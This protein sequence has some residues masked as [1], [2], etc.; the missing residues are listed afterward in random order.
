MNNP[1]IPAPKDDTSVSD[2]RTGLASS[3]SQTTL[4]VET[5]PPAPQKGKDQPALDDAWLRDFYKE[6]GR[7][8]TL[9][10]TTLNQMKN[11]AIVVQ[12]SIIAAV[13]AF[14]R[15]L[16]SSS[17]S[18]VGSQ[19]G[20]AVVVGAVLAHLFTLRFFVRA[21]LC[22]INLLRWNKLQSA[23]VECKLVRREVLRGQPNPQAEPES[24][25]RKA[26]QDYYFR[27]LSP[28][29][30]PAQIA[31]NLKLGFGLLLVLPAV[32]I[33]WGTAVHWDMLVVRGLVTFAIIGTLIEVEDY[34]LAGFFDT[35]DR[36]AERKEDKM[37][38]P[39]PSGSIS[40][41]SMWDINSLVSTGVA[42]GPQLVNFC[43]PL[44][45]PGEL[46]WAVTYALAAYL[47][48]YIAYNGF[49]AWHRRLTQWRG[50]VLMS[51]LALVALTVLVVPSWIAV[52]AAASTAAIAGAGALL[53]P[54][55]QR[56]Q[57][58]A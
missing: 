46:P 16:L 28:V 17:G 22:Y 20:I 52:I 15:S 58:D 44:L 12:A 45:V 21:I 32:L 56:V 9:A 29:A 41:V 1:S 35:P 53:R 2:M 34:L 8:V 3:G 5:E 36:A 40:Y 19:I 43:H 51:G 18:D 49:T 26:I 25:L 14:G 31:S 13:A 47:L 30:R 50:V 11:W 57:G 54:S 37:I 23:V 6:C 48:A 7:E 42:F 38:F 27:W 39:A 55:R 10:Y 33:A 4:G 24:A